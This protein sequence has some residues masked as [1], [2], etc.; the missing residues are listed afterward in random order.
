MRRINQSGLTLIKAAE[1]CSLKAYPDPGTGGE[2]WT[3]GYGHT[4][5]VRRGDMISHQRAED[6]LRED[7]RK[8]E[9]GVEHL[10]FLDATDNQFSALVSF[11]FNVGLNNLRVSTLLKKFNAGD[12][13]GAADEFIRWNRAAGKILSGLTTRRLAERALFLT[14]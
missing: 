3:I 10:L 11:A 14:A 7:L 5:G 9:T 4:G 2:P 12:A 13:H 8:F 6:L 1:G